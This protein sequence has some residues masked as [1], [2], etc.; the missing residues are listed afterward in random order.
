[1]KEEGLGAKE[2]NEGR[3]EAQKGVAHAARFLG[4]VGPTISALVALL[5]SIFLPESSS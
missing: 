5:P 1:M 4:R 3:P 2:A